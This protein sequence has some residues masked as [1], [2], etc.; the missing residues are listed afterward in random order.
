MNR[1]TLRALLVTSLLSGVFASD[2][3]AQADSGSGV[4]PLA[5]EVR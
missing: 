1:T 2:T 4:V 5:V 3:F